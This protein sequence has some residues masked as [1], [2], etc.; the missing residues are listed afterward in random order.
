MRRNN[1]GFGSFEDWQ[2][3]VIE[4]EIIAQKYLNKKIAE[5]T[6]WLHKR[7]HRPPQTKHG[8]TAAPATAA[9]GT[10]RTNQAGRFGQHGY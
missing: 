9:A 10:A 1:K 3:Q 8:K 6:E 7:R 4:Q 5:E 2:D